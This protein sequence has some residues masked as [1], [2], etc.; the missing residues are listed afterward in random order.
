MLEIM[1]QPRVSTQH[2]GFGPLEQAR[3]GPNSDQSSITKVFLKRL[4]R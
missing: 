4:I 3:N 2:S 1:Q